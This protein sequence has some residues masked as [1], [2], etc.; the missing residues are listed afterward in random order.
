MRKHQFRCN[1]LSTPV[2]SQG[3]GQGGG[4]GADPPENG[5]VFWPQRGACTSRAPN[6]AAFGVA[7]LA[8]NRQQE[9]GGN[10][11]RGR[12]A[13]C[14]AVRESEGSCKTRQAPVAG[15][16]TRRGV[17]LP[18]E[19]EGKRPRGRR[20]RCILGGTGECFPE[21][22][23]RPRDPDWLGRGGRQGQDPLGAFF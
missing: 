13:F 22:L 3:L 5:N 8:F 18:G 20:G 19:D 1:R 4:G 2:K 9:A 21:T 10:G 11:G 14:P 7:H 12:L 6:T 16:E 15:A 17:G 23:F